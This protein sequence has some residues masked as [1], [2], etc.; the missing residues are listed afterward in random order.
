[1]IYIY[2]TIAF[3]AGIFFAIGLGA[4]LTY[5]KHYEYSRKRDK[6]NS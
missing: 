2:L 5:V 4:F 6:K 3:I 1:M